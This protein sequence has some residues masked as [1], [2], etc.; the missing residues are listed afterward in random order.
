MNIALV[1]YGA[2]NIHSAAKALRIAGERRGIA[3]I[4]EA[5]RDPEK[6]R[7]ADRVVLPGDGAFAHCMAELKGAPGVMAALE[8]TVRREKKPFLGICVGMQ[9]LAS[10]SEEH[11][12]HQGLG[13]LPGKI[14][15]LSPADAK[16]KIPHMGW[17]EL[18]PKRAHPALAGLQLGPEGQTAYFLHSY[19]FEAENPADIIAVADYCGAVTA[20][21]A[22][23]NILGCQ[24]HPEKSQALGLSLIGNFLAWRP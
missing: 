3:V 13:W 14:R 2:G 21:V 17:N 9:M 23:E 11:G 22:R 4:V 10:S 24:F 1:D 20:V 8:H 16:L 5:T 7:A 15:R 18:Y 12:E 6:I 19:H